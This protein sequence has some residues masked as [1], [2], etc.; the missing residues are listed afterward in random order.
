MPSLQ[1]ELTWT[2]LVSRYQK[3]SLFKGKLSERWWRIT[4][5]KCWFCNNLQILL[6]WL[7][8]KDFRVMLEIEKAPTS[9]RSQNQA[10]MP[11][12]TSYFDE[13]LQLVRILVVNGE[14]K[15]NVEAVQMGYWRA[16]TWAE[17][18]WMIALHSSLQLSWG[19]QGRRKKWIGPENRLLK[20]TR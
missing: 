15:Q 6:C 9:Q 20:G 14:K 2:Y 7:D 19:T 18:S 10:N 8:L 1:T 16:K 11:E 5:H 12:N 4:C 17:W 3:K 13:W